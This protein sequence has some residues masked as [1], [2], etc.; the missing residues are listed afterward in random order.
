M[1]RVI[2]ITGSGIGSTGPAMHPRE[3]CRS[4]I[5][6]SEIDPAGGG[7]MSE[8]DLVNGLGMPSA[9]TSLQNMP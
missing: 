5:T 4:C 7:M 3:S 6:M 2:V 9:H 1:G 8:I